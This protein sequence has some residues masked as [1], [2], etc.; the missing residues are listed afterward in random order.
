[1]SSRAR[2]KARGSGHTMQLPGHVQNALNKEERLL[3]QNLADLKAEADYKVRSLSKDQQVATK[4]LIIMEKQMLIS[5]ARSAA[6]MTSSNIKVKMAPSRPSTS[7]SEYYKTLLTPTVRLQEEDKQSN[8]QAVK[9]LSK[10][11]K[12]VSFSMWTVKI[13]IVRS[14]MRF[15]H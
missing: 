2:S 1:M 11:R 12:S 3:Q 10:A 5:Q 4:K 9:A 6:I 7:S 13:S 14:V 8:Q 15:N